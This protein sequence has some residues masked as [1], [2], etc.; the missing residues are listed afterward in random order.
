MHTTRRAALTAALFLLLAPAFAQG[1]RKKSQI[2]SIQ[3]TKGTI[4]IK[5]FPEVTPFTV[6]NFL[7][8]VKKGFYNGLTFHRVE[9]HFVIQGGDPEGNGSGGPGWTIKNEDNKKLRHNR[10]AVAM[11]NAGPDT[12]GSQFYI[13]ISDDPKKPATFLDEKDARGI[14]KY[15][16]F[17]QVIKGQEIA[18]K[19]AKGDKMIKVSVQP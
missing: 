5:L 10:G 19:I 16:I 9:P 15:T 6:A 14:S 1:A 8:L 13:V 12:A 18:E 2:V 11:A 7:K 4:K 17:G 3:T